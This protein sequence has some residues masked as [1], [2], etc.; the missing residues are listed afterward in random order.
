MYANQTDATKGAALKRFLTFVLNDGQELA[1]P[2]Q[3]A[4]LPASLQQRA[5]GQLEQLKIPA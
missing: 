2:T 3:Y 4:K 5:V 1:E